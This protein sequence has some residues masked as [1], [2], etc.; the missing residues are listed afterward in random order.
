MSAHPPFVHKQFEE[1]LALYAL[2]ALAAAARAVLEA[3]LSECA[4]CRRELEQLRGDSALLAL[5][6]AQQTPP[7]RTRERL[8]AAFAAERPGIRAPKARLPWLWLPS[9]AAAVLVIVA[10]VLWREDSNLRR[11]MAG[12]E[13]AY[14]Q[15]QSAL[16]SANEIVST[17]A[18]PAAAR[19][20]LSGVNTPPRPQGK[21]IYARNR[22]SL[23]FI[24]SNMPPLP[25]Q[26]A[27]ELWLIPITGA[28]I[29]AGLFKPDSAG[30]A[31][32]VN[33]PLSAY[34]EAKTFAITVEPEA[35]S[36]APT[37]QPIM[38]GSG[39]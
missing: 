9:F 12:L 3:H 16:R 19:F 2:G 28:P 13:K 31:T 21:A 37:S 39:G 24:A 32:L 34:V 35:G 25:P 5:S 8:M 11:Q 27:Y 20:T 1:D 18:D 7:A 22:G 23:I 26:K 4:G 29:P 15:Q 36:S 6:V 14:S 38:L 17:L 10:F 33:P 30:G